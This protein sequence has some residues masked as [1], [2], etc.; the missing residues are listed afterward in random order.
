MNKIASILSAIFVFVGTTS[1]H[2]SI[3]GNAQP[4][5]HRKSSSIAKECK[6]RK[7][8]L[9]RVHHCYYKPLDGNVEQNGN[10][11]F[12]FAGDESDLLTLDPTTGTFTVSEAGNYLISYTFNVFGQG[13][14]SFGV[15]L[16]NQTI[17]PGTMDQ[18]HSSN[19]I[20]KGLRVK[21]LVIASLA[22]GDTINIINQTPTSVQFDCNL[23]GK[24]NGFLVIRKFQQNRT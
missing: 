7:P 18:G 1:I 5:E 3:I 13:T 24:R 17:L 19:D 22:A 10:V 4:N 8:F 20:A 9:Q 2:S 12:D 23:S 16:N 21:S 14:P 6:D 15:L 11:I